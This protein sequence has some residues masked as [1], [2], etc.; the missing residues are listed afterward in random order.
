MLL[1][2]I[3]YITETDTNGDHITQK[4]MH[5]KLQRKC[6]TLLLT[7]NHEKLQRWSNI[8][9]YVRLHSTKVYIYGLV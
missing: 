6:Q 8:I 4:Y 9:L 3:Y 7:F 5:K 1:R 2:R